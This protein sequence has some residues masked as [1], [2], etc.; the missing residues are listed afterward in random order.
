MNWIEI[1]LWIRANDPHYRLSY[2]Q[3]LMVESAL[4]RDDVKTAQKYINDFVGK[5]S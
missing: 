4:M 1:G 5:R 2:V 3:H